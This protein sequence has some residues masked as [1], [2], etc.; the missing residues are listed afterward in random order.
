MP[1]C[2]SSLRKA[3]KKV[4]VVL[5]LSCLYFYL[6]AGAFLVFTFFTPE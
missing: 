4:F 2:L 6:L 1:N 5:F 3:M